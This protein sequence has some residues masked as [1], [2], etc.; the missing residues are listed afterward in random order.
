LHL[1]ADFLREPERL[2]ACYKKFDFGAGSQHKR[3]K[4]GA[5]FNEVLTVVK[6]QQEIFATKCCQECVLR[7]FP[8]LLRDG[9]SSSYAVRKKFRIRQ[10]SE[11]DKPDSIQ[12][13]IEEKRGDLE[14]KTGLAHA[15]GSDERDEMCIFEQ[16]PDLRHIVRASQKCRGL[17]WQ[18]IWPN[19]Q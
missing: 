17:N 14:C 10:W 1:P 18:I 16:F 6:Q 5:R 11:V 7:S 12:M 4:P 2:P 19:G 9:E 3:C 13:D 15:A 8:L